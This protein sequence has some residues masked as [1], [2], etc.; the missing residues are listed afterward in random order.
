MN[1]PFLKKPDKD[2][3]P[4]TQINEPSLQLGKGMVS[5]QDIIAPPAIEVYFDFL[6]IG[7]KYFRTL[8]IA[9]IFYY[10]C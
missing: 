8:F 1:L 6:K 2:K 5:V 7:N 3:E 9:I 4:E 10:C